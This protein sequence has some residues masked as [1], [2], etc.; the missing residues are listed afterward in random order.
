MYSDDRSRTK[1]FLKK[2]EAHAV[3][4]SSKP[5]LRM[6]A[7]IRGCLHCDIETMNEDEFAIAWGQTKYYLEVVHQVEFK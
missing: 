3:S 1:R 6:A 4:N 2:I 5:F 7:L